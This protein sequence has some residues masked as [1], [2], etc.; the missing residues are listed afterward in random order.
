MT[1]DLTFD[2]RERCADEA[3]DHY[4]EART[5][6]VSAEEAQ[7]SSV[8]EYQ[9]CLLRQESLYRIQ[10]RLLKKPCPT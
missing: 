7:R 10:Q 3:R 2:D 8:A 6:G 5:N 1:H 4:R 9:A